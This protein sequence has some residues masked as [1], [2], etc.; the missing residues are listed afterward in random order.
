MASLLLSSPAG[1]SWK[2]VTA[3]N[4][5]RS[6]STGFKALYGRVFL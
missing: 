5:R 4:S 2:K 1:G 6:L 3:A